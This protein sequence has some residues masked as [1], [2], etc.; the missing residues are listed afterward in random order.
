M[1][2]LFLKRSSLSMI[3]RRDPVLGF[4]LSLSSC[5]LFSLLLPIY[6]FSHLFCFT[7]FCPHMKSVHVVIYLCLSQFTALE[8]PSFF[9]LCL[10]LILFLSNVC[11]LDFSICFFHILLF[12][13][14]VLSP[15]IPATLPLFS[16]VLFLSSSTTCVKKGNVASSGPC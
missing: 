11:I 7:F 9:P 14:S 10:S 6:S 2:S 3:A 13:F 16:V 15:P 8:V 1:A 12:Y 5:L 4:S